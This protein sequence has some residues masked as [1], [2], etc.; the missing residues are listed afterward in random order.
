MTKIG[1]T[2]Y[3]DGEPALVTAVDPG[4]EYGERVTF[5]RDGSIITTTPG[6]DDRFSFAPLPPVEDGP[7][8][9]QPPPGSWADVARMMAQ[10]D[11]SGFDWDAWKDEMKERDWED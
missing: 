9:I 11:D 1:D 10:G 4:G 5:N 6:L 3:Y 7:F 2:V 8:P